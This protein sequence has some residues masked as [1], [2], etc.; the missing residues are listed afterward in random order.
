[1]LLAIAA[2]SSVMIFPASAAT[3]GSTNT[4]SISV[5]TTADWRYPGTESITLKQ[6]KCKYTYSTLKNWKWVDKESSAYPYYRITIKNETTGKSTSKTWHSASI[7]LK[8]DRNARYT[9]TVSYDS[10]GNWLGSNCK[11]KSWKNTPSW[12][13]STTHKAN[14]W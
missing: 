12:W 5:Q 3:S 9:I 14:A 1:M 7:K 4:R 10:M 6:N 11:F 13:V 8:L 2:L